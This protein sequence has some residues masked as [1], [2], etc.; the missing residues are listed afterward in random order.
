MISTTKNYLLMLSSESRKR[1]IN[2]FSAEVEEFSVLLGK[3]VQMLQNYQRTEPAFDEGDPKQVA[4]GLMTKN[5][6]TL[7]AGFELAIIGY[8]AE[9]FILHRSA[10]EG[11]ATAWDLVHNPERFTDWRQS[12]NFGSTASIANLK[13]EIPVI[14]RMYGFLSNLKVHTAPINSLPAIFQ[15]QAGPII[16]LFGFVPEGKEQTRRTEVMFSL[17]AAYACLQVAELVFHRYAAELETI[18]PTT[19]QD[20]QDRVVP[21]VSARHRPFADAAIEH[22]RSLTQDPSISL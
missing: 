5:A 22:F 16:Q 13:R 20:R 6:N 19:E 17:L 18:A 10:L 14:G 7:V 4:Y 15:L 1:S 21:I 12:K 8:T 9:P 3:L 2:F 11:F